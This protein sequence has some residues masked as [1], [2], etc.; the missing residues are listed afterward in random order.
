MAASHRIPLMR[1]QWRVEEDYRDVPD[2]RE[3][4]YRDRRRPSPPRPTIQSS[5]D[6]GEEAKGRGV[7]DC[8]LTPQDRSQ[9]L[10]TSKTLQRRVGKKGNH[11]PERRSLNSEVPTRN[12]AKSSEKSERQ[13]TDRRTYQGGTK[14]PTRW[15]ETRS[16]SSHRDS[17]N[18]SGSGRRSH[19][20]SY[21]AN[22]NRQAS[23]IGRR[24]ERADST[25]SSNQIRRCPS[26]E[27]N[28]TSTKRPPRSSYIPLPSALSSSRAHSCSRDLSPIRQRS[29]SA[30]R[31]HSPRNLSPSYARAVSH[32]KH[33][34]GRH[35][36]SASSTYRPR[37]QSKHTSSTS[38]R[39]YRQ[40]QSPSLSPVESR[41]SDRIKKPGWA[42]IETES[43]QGRIKEM[44]SST[45]PIQSILDESTQPPSPPQPIPSFDSDS[46]SGGV[47]ETFSSHSMK[48]TELHTGIRP[49]RPQV[50]T[51]QSYSTSPQ[52]TPTS[53]HHGSPQSG[54][55]FSRGRAGW[56]GQQQQHFHGQQRYSNL[57]A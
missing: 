10:G 44:Q 38:T 19:S 55:P 8:I 20:P 4:H 56:T 42:V 9:D 37:S 35:R 2:R 32:R 47:R 17:Y 48:T 21:S 57:L 22:H 3:R 13:F 15:R 30:R 6:R 52:W 12:L 16:P 54:S 46:H 43:P 24:R 11:S 29:R 34:L 41:L 50:D 25:S 33:S 18:C 31:R 40:R 45:H 7:A 36:E 27:D 5:I 53:S 28:S 26:N 51:R 14:P 1:H 23:R 49:G 39:Q